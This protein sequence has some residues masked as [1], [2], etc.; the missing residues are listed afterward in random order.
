MKKEIILAIFDKASG[1][2]D[3]CGDWADYQ[4]IEP[5]RVEFAKLLDEVYRIQGKAFLSR[6][7]PKELEMLD[8]DI[9]AGMGEEF[10]I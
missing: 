8:A 4:N 10:M 3:A 2:G 5:V 7:S 9:E 1:Y 6:L